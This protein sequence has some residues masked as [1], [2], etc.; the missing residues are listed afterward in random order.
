MESTAAAAR[1]DYQAR[2]FCTLVA[3]EFARPAEEVLES[4]ALH[5]PQVLTCLGA[6]FTSC[7]EALA[8][9]KYK[10]LNPQA[11]PLQAPKPITNDRKELA[12][13]STAK[14]ACTAATSLGAQVGPERRL[15]AG[16]V[17]ASMAPGRKEVPRVQFVPHNRCRVAGYVLVLPG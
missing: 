13:G 3:Y 7:S 9:A 5:T 1:R 12:C 11:Y 14:L 16:R 4:L 15:L 2:G 17:A 10:I 6:S 8:V